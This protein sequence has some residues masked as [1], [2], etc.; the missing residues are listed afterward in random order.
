DA[1]AV[2][3]ADDV[4]F[5][6]VHEPVAIG[7]D[8]GPGGGIVEL[9]SPRDHDI[10]QGRGSRGVHADVIAGD[11]RVS[12]DHDAAIDHVSLV[13]GERVVRTV[14]ADDK[15]GE[16]IEDAISAVNDGSAAGDVR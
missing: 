16:A 15:A 8:P 14:H 11:H 12:G 2:K 7:A 3:P 1:G 6:V 5:R 4:A 13:R 10:R 9:D